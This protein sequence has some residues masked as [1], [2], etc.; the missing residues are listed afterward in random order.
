VQAGLTAAITADQA[1]FRSAARGGQDALTL[2]EAGMIV[3]ALVMAAGCGMGLSPR[4][5]EYR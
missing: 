2:L 3:A 5:A 4:L 1:T